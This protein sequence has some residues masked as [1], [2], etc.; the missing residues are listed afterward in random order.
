MRV[1]K[2]PTP[3][4][5]ISQIEPVIFLAGSIEMGTARDWQQEITDALVD[6]AITILNPRRDDWDWTWKQSIDNPVFYEQVNW[7]LD[8]LERADIIFF[9]FEPTAKSPIS[10]LELGLFAPCRKA[11]VHCPEGFWRKGNVD[12]VCER[13]ELDHVSS[14][15]EGVELIKRHC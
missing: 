15:D 7:E 14:I 13:Y 3:L 8:A 4:D 10:L 6:T 1:I 2:P 12:I 5:T 9:N 11:I